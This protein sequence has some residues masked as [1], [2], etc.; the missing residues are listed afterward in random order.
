MIDERRRVL[1]AAS[2]GLFVGV[3]LSVACS[4]TKNVTSPPPGQ[5]LT[6]SIVAGDEATC[7]LTQAGIAYCWGFD[8]AGALGNDS[9]SGSRLT[10]GPV[11]GNH[12]FASLSGSELFRC[13]LAGQQPLCWGQ[14]LVHHGNLYSDSEPTS[15]ALGA[16]PLASITVGPSHACGLTTDGVAYCWGE[17][18]FGQLGVGDTLPRNMAVAVAG[19]QKWTAI[20]AG[21]WHTC[22]LTADSVAFCWG[23]NLAGELAAPPATLPLSTTP[24]A[25]GG[26]FKFTSLSAGSLYTCGLTATGAAYCWGWNFAGNLGD[27]TTTNRE[28]PTPIAGNLQFKRIVA[29]SANSI[30]LTTCGIAMSNA[31]YCWGWGGYLQLGSASL[32]LIICDSV[33]ANAAPCGS[34]APLAVDGGLQFASVSVGTT[35]VCGVTTS[36]AAYCWGLNDHGQLGNGSED[37]MSVPVP[38]SG[39]LTALQR[40]AARIRGGPPRRPILGASR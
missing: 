10:P 23:E 39:N 38:V 4:G 25:I 14:T 30:V 17:N 13:G 5:Q 8:T 15:V 1:I 24:V 18:Y 32:P 29:S 40:L 34:L 11:A 12:T 35:H 26:G 37:R 22:A 9:V 31:L 3:S 16:P 28:A 27:S 2:L 36:A 33:P 21:F 6:G 20:S 19:G 7:L